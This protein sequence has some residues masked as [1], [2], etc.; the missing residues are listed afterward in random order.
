MEIEKNL[1]VNWDIDNKKLIPVRNIRLPNLE[2][3]FERDFAFPDVWVYETEEYNLDAIN[4]IK[5]R[6]KYFTVYFAR[7]F[8]YNIED[9]S[10]LAIQMAGQRILLFSLYDDVLFFLRKM[11]LIKESAGLITASKALIENAETEN[12]RLVIQKHS[13]HVSDISHRIAT[14]LDENEEDIKLAGYIHD[15]GKICIP[16]SLLFSDTTF[17]DQKVKIFQLHALWGEVL[18]EKLSPDCSN[19][20]LYESVGFHHERLNGQGYFRGLKKNIPKVAKIIAVSD[21]YSALTQ[22]RPHR[23]HFDKDV[24]ITYISAKAGELFDPE[25]VDAFKKVI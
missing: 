11:M 10:S 12:E 25:V 6:A 9:F 21:V 3:S 16:A 17:D 2:I 4:R 24:A 13:Q 8:F 18:F 14:M 19:K 23:L 7:K 15:I 20:V 22:D 1:T 5:D